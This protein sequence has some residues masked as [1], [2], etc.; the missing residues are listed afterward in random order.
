MEMHSQLLI[1]LA[2]PI[3]TQTLIKFCSWRSIALS[4][5]L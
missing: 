4:R 1:S 5:Q 3:V 2:V